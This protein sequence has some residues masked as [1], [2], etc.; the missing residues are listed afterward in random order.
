MNFRS[1]FRIFVFLWTLNLS[2]G[3]F[4]NQFSQ[5]V[6]TKD[7]THADITEIGILQAVAEYFESTPATPGG[8]TLVVGKWA[9]IHNITAKKLFDK[10]YGGNMLCLRNNSWKPYVYIVF[11]TGRPL[12]HEVLLRTLADIKAYPW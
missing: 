10:Y 4:A 1:V 5:F 7:Y 12:C 3:F 6:G 11:T 2:E 8:S 9:G